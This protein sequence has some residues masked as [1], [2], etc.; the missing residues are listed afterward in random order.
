MDGRVDIGAD[1]LRGPEL[2]G[3][4]IAGPNEILEETTA[5]YEA[6]ALYG[7][8]SSADVTSLTQWLVEPNEYAD[9]DEPGLLIPEDMYEPVELTVYAH[10]AEGEYSAAAS[11]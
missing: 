5:Q 9:I 8:G 6:I 11:R 10:Y 7:D 3:L 4:E 1:E 2:V